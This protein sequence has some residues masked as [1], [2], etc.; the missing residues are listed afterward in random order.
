MKIPNE[1]IERIFAQ[2]QREAPNEACGYLIGTA[3]EVKKAIPMTNVDGSPEHFSLDPRE[4]FAA[5]RQARAEGL[6]ILAVYH[7][8]PAT[9]ARPSA[10]DI[11]LAYDPAIVYV[12]VSLVPDR[13][14][15]KA[16]RIRQGTVTEETLIVEENGHDG[17][18]VR[19]GSKGEMML[20]YKI[21]GNYSSEIDEL[22]GLVGRLQSGAMTAAELRA[23]RVPFG[24]YEQRLQGSFM[25]RIRCAAG[26]ITP[27]QLRRVA[28][29]A[30]EFGSG[31]L[32]VTT[33]QEI[34]MH[35]VPLENMVPAIRELAAVG[36]A[37]R[38]GG[39]NTVR[40][41][42]ASWDSGIAPDEVFDV[43]PHA[44]ELTSRL[45]AMG[46]SWLLPR[47]FKIAF[48]NS[49]ADNAFATA[50]DVGFIASMKGNRRGFRVFVAGGMGRAP[51]PG[52]LL[53]EFIAEDEVFLVAEAV[54]RLFSKLGNRRNKHSARLRFL[55]NT[56]GRQ[57]F[58][59]EYQKQ[60]AAL[61]A[62]RPAPFVPPVWSDTA[63]TPSGV[64]ALDEKSPEFD[65]WK[66]RYVTAQRQNGLS[67]I[68]VPLPLG[69]ISSEKAVL[70]ADALSPFGDNTL[71]CTAD[72]NLLLRN[73]P[74]RY[75]GNLFAVV[76]Q[77]SASWDAPK[78]FANAVACAGASTCQLGICL[79]RGALDA[80]IDRLNASD[81]DIESLDA[82]RLY[83]SGCSNSCGRH[84]LAHLGFFG[85]A[86]RK[87]NH[88]YPAYTVVAGVKIDSEQGSALAHRI[89]DISAR[90]VP[91]FVEEF[92][93]HYVS[94]K[95]SFSSFDDYLATEGEDHIR[96]LCDKYRDIPTMKEDESYYR[97]WGAQEPFSL[98]G[99]GTG[100]CAAGLF[101]LIDLDLEKVRADRSGFE[102]EN[103]PAA[104]SAILHRLVVTAARSLL[105]TQGIEAATDQEALAHFERS[106]VDAGLV[107][108]S[109]RPVIS[110]AR[111][112]AETLAAL[113]DRALAFSR[114]I[115]TLH[116]SMDDTLQFHP[117]KPQEDTGDEG[118]SATV[119]LVKDL[120]G[121]ACP[122]NFVKTKMALS[123]I[124]AGQVLQVLLDDGEPIENVPRSVEAEG[125][126]V[127]DQTRAG[128]HWTVTIRKAQQ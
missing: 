57:R 123:Q 24:V 90:D 119:D 4:Q 35:D 29:L 17:S 3:G 124:Q 2:G 13:R 40:N 37:S 105:I 56:L 50:N 15:A 106:F 71:R 22:E 79:S 7:T 92:L 64:A 104:R 23:R 11:R 60:R 95:A 53:H 111:T 115:E 128:E 82:F 81:I 100:E 26:I 61:E 32:H 121:V 86:A 68:L 75:L 5:L 27:G 44:V 19:S 31:R 99:R 85:K 16:F 112:G 98:A 67:S 12:I 109:F 113:S 89:G 34:Q 88:S 49:G 62:E 125:H 47:K 52:Q 97:D 9:P 48:S 108:E 30:S 8:H 116:A 41:V 58:I 83:L 66:K 51:Q 101:D 114:Q 96:T 45:I 110:A 122:M 127:L 87:G 21:P 118:S 39:G 28:D 80:I 46:D 70:L 74:D 72:Q 59:E 120:R 117:S 14:E 54:K 91:R 102:A 42:I 20:A 25:I 43:T 10:E 38:G 77:V 93:G 69:D 84:G 73:I 76:R 6:E 55:W 78:L 65:L 103:D 1:I 94:R 63:Q 36:L 126:H 107:A 33:R 18:R